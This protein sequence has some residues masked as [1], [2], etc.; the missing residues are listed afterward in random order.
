MQEGCLLYGERSFY[1]VTGIIASLLINMH[2]C[3][4][5]EPYG[6]EKVA[7]FYGIDIVLINLW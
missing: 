6:S 3:N 1:Y 2:Y 4:Y 7:L 5:T